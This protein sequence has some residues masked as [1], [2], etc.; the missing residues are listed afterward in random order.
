MDYSTASKKSFSSFYHWDTICYLLVYRIMFTSCFST[1]Y[2]SS[3][4]KFFS[5]NCSAG[6]LSQNRI[7]DSLFCGF[8]I[9]KNEKRCSR[10]S[11]DCI[12]YYSWSISLRVW[13]KILF[14]F[15]DCFSFSCK[16][17]SFLF[18]FFSDW[19]RRICKRIASLFTSRCKNN[20]DIWRTLRFSCVFSI[21]YSYI[22]CSLCYSKKYDSPYYYGVVKY[23]CHNAS[24]FYLFPYLFCCLFYW[25]HPNTFF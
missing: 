15:L 4:S 23:L 8:F 3:F 9:S 1:I 22:Y 18:S 13:A 14:I 19:Q 2:W 5:E 11:R 7:Y 16:T 21:Y 12:V 20:I 25:S 6:I 24:Y 17:I 10:L